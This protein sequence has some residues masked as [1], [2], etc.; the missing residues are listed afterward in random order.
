[1]NH[2]KFLLPS[3]LALV[4]STLDR[5]RVKDPRN[6]LMFDILL[7]T[8]A[9]SSEMLNLRASD[10]NPEAETLFFRGLKGSRDRNVPVSPDLFKRV[11]SHASSLHPSD[12]LFNIS[13]SRLQQLWALY[14]PIPK[15][16]HSLRHTFAIELYRRT[17][18]LFLVQRALGHRNLFTTLIYQDHVYGVDEMRRILDID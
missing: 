7:A 16:L 18:D 3:E 5:F 2:H 6:V 12:C 14:R 17:K 15:P 11:A 10:L 1:M 4:R 8:G 9:R 13:Y